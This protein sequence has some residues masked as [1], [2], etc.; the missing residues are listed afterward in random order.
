MMIAIDVSTVKIFGW[1]MLIT[2]ISAAITPMTTA[3][4]IGVCVFGIHPRELLAERQRVVAR[5]RERQPDGGGVHGQRAH[6]H[7]DDDADQED[8]AQ[9]AP[10]HLLDDVLQ[11]A[12]AARRSAGRPGWA[13]T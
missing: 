8:L 12:A 10:H 5:H 2:R 4:M 1:P 9:R 3:G 7:R 11:A 6:R 13:P